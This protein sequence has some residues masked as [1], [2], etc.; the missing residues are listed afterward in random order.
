[1]SFKH[2]FLVIIGSLALL[3]T[4]VL[5]PAWSPGVIE[6]ELQSVTTLDDET[7]E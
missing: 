2:L 7:R 6:S 1:M 5:R 4:A 3:L